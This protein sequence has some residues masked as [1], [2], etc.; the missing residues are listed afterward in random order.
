MKFHI[1]AVKPVD[2]PVPYRMCKHLSTSCRIYLLGT[3]HIQFLCEKKRR[4]KLNILFIKINN[5]KL[6]TFLFEKIF[7]IFIEIAPEDDLL[8]NLVRLSDELLLV[9][10]IKKKILLFPGTSGTILYRK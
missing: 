2:I 7:E 4:K 6:E 1:L 8:Q 10:E 5:G 3:Y 9:S